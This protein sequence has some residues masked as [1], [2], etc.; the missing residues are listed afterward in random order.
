MT[1]RVVAAHR[2]AGS[3]FRLAGIYAGS[4]GVVGSWAAVRGKSPWAGIHLFLAGTVLLVISGAAPLFVITWAA[5]R[6]PRPE[7]AAAQR[8]SLALGVGMVVVGVEAGWETALVAGG[9]S[10]VSG[11]CLLGY[12][13]VASIRRSLLRRFDLSTRFYLLALAGGMVGVTV[14][15]LLALGVFES[16]YLRV[17]TVHLHLNLVGLVGLTIFGT[18]P[19]FLPTLAH[20]RMVSGVEARVAWWAAA[21]S[22]AAMVGGLVGGFEMVG[23]GTLG[24]AAAGAAIVTGI[25]LRLGSRV[26]RNGLPPMQVLA[27]LVWLWGWLVVDGS[28]LITGRPTPVFGRATVAVVVAGVGQILLGSLTYLVPVVAGRGAVGVSKGRPGVALAA[29]NLA[30]LGLVLGWDWA[31]FLVGIWVWDFVDR[32]GR[33]LIGRTEAH[34]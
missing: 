29:A 11:L 30:G 22:V 9:V 4:A 32:V 24:V 15:I 18:L 27:G 3:A 17:R 25:L 13:L 28:G 26:V 19:T 7:V 23:W 34:L 2:L 1:G 20:H 8:W 5:S 31:W 16:T 14:G 6:P 33:A 21:A 12:M 10:V